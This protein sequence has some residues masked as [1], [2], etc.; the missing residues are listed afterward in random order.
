MSD[1]KVQYISGTITAGNTSATLTAPTDFQAVSALNGAFI[2]PATTMPTCGLGNAAD[3]GEIRQWAVSANM[4]AVGSIT[5]AR[6]TSTN[7]MPF[8]FWI[9]EYTGV[10]G[11]PNEFIVRDRGEATFASAAATMESAGIAGIT[12]LARCVPFV[13]G[14]FNTN[15][16]AALRNFLV[17]AVVQN[18]GVADVIAFERILT[19]G[20]PT[21]AWQCVEF[22]GSNWTVQIGRT[23]NYEAGVDKNQAIATV[24]SLAKTW[25]FGYFIA[26][27]QSH[28]QSGTWYAWLSSTTNLRS[29]TPVV[30]GQSAFRWFVIENADPTFSVEVV[31][32]VDGSDDFV[33]GASPQTETIPVTRTRSTKIGR[34]HV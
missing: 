20:L 25:V 29:R 34:A 3:L 24:A 16:S 22:T 18:N 12:N 6:A 10:A 1:F 21:F 2:L 17:E 13:S 8:A 4:T 7:D 33:A 26:A 5:V 11:G 23:A 30:G 19:T 9:I 27:N 31:N 28:P 32:A 15:T 14:R